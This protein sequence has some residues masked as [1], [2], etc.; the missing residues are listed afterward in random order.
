M[1]DVYVA[2]EIKYGKGEYAEPVL[3][4]G[5]VS[6]KVDMFLEGGGTKLEQNR[7]TVQF[8]ANAPN[9][10]SITENS[11]FWIRRKPD[12]TKQGGDWTHIVRGRDG[13]ST[14]WFISIEVQSVA[15]NTPIV[16]N[17]HEH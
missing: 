17:E 4:S 5:L 11:H 9:A 6:P 16:Y 7:E 10:E 12:P 13:S 2:S 15:G 14:S 3:I 1:Q 8:D